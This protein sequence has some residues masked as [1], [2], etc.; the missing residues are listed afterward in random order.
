MGM[1]KECITCGASFNGTER[2]LA[3]FF[4]EQYLKNG[5]SRYVYRLSPSSGFMFVRNDHFEF[6]L[7]TQIKPN[8]KNGAEY[9]HISE[10]R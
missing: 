3:L 1:S 7:K 10:L 8:F 6:I 4:K 2:D 5:I 9:F